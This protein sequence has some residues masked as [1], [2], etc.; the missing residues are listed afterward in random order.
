MKETFMFVL[1]VLEEERHVLLLTFGCVGQISCSDVVFGQR[2]KW[3]AT[4]EQCAV[5]CGDTDKFSVLVV[6][7]GDMDKF[8]VLACRGIDKFVTFLNIL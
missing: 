1:D 4:T 7:C 8:S 2:A 3:G 6:D 5:A